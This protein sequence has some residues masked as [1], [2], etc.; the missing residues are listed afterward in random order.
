MPNLFQAG[1]ASQLQET[2]PTD[3]AVQGRLPDWLTGT[4]VRN[5][6][7]QYEVGAQSYRHWFDG[8]AMLHAFSFGEGRVRYAS[9]FLQS[10]SYLDDNAGGRI[11][12]GGFAIEPCRTLFRR[13]FALFSAESGL[14]ANV[15]VAKLADDWVA[16]TETPLAVRFDPAT[17]ETLGVLPFEDSHKGQ[18][19]T[20]HPLLDAERGVAY[21][22]LLRFGRHDPVYQLYALHGRRRQIVARI[23]T[24]HASYL[25]SIGMSRQYLILIEYPFRLARPL[26]LL[27]T[28]RPF[29]ENYAWR[30]DLPTVFWVV[31]KDTGAVLTRAEGPPFFAFHHINAWE[32]GDSVMVDVAAYDGPQLI[33]QLLLERVRADDA[34]IDCARLLR[35][36]VPLAG[37]PVTAGPVGEALLELPRIDERRLGRTCQSVYGASMNP[38]DHDFLN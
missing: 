27:F 30:D 20:A 3:L 16:M 2:P 7:A 21:N 11:H 33:E 25:H 36:R 34:G 1:F 4:L 37:G 9:R 13:F 26:D 6:P 17:L 23:E 32:E 24:A 35:C 19:S 38:G 15:S 18:L 31:D 14:N 28:G 29:I 22:L 10:P 8:L 12:Y 5:G